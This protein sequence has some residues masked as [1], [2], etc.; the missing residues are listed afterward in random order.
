[1]EKA[2][3]IKTFPQSY[4]ISLCGVVVRCSHVEPKVPG[5]SFTQL[6]FSF[7]LFPPPFL[8]CCFL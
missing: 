4:V 6:F 8:G 5:S 3:D 1:M 7:F 2:L